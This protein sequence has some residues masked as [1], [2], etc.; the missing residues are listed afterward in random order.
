MEIV[1]V[2]A[3]LTGANA[4]AALRKNGFDGRIVLLG[5]EMERPYERPPL[6]KETLRG[7]EPHRPLYVHGPTFYEDNGIDF[8]PGTVVTSLDLNAQELRIADGSIVPWDR[9]LLA[10]GGTAH[11]LPVPGGDLEGVV[12]LLTLADALALRQAAAEARRI[13]VV[14]GGWI[15]AEVAASLR[16]MDYAVTLVTPTGLP[17]ERVLGPEVA[18]VYRDLHLAHGVALRPNERVVGFAAAHGAKHV[19]A[20]LTAD[21]TRIPADLVVLGVGSEPRSELAA[22]AGLAIADGGIAV[23]EQLQTEAP[24]V[25]AAGDVAAALHPVL[26]TRLRVEHWDNARRQG[27]LAAANMLG[28]E[29]AYSVIPYFY[30]DQFDLSMEYAGHVTE[31]DR[32]VFRGDPAT[33]SFLAFWLRGDIVVAGMN[34]NVD[35]IHPL[36][37]RLVATRL[38]IDVARLSDPAVPLEDLLPP[39]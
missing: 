24:G 34:A 37:G 38:P 31:W 4:A 13:V 15:G 12:T 5:E 30:S 35:G 27:R 17:L 20:V 25:F 2:G 39:V 16:Q 19:E 32:V 28:G 3:A 14:G 29:K 6:S 36:I 18:A 21:G 22:A 1:I 10:T 8:R 11:R 33:R 7:E 9:L 26:R 23:D